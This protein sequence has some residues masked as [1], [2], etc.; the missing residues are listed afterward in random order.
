MVVGDNIL[1]PGAPQYLEYVCAKPTG[2]QA[3]RK[4][5]YKTERLMGHIEYIPE[6]EVRVE[7]LLGFMGM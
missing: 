5:Y 7:N 1:F 2:G 3:N 4:V 6:I